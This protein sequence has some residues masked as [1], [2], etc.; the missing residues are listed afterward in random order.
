MPDAGARDGL[1]PDA[2]AR[3]GLPP[4]A[5]AR[6]AV[7]PDGPR[8]KDPRR[9]L[10]AR[11]E[12]LA[13]RHLEA[14][15]FEVVERNFRTRYGELDVIARDARFLVFCE[16]KTRIVRGAAGRGA[17]EDVLGPF[18]AIGPRKQRQ[19][20]A[21]AREWLSQASLDGPGGPRLSPPRPPEIRFDAI[22]I[23]FDASGR[24]LSLEHL[25]AAF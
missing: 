11:G 17:P 6:D 18:A 16:V 23:G 24:L 25:E 8:P 2:N 19:V 22:G 12:G 3:D 9:A 20:R 14:R 7:A 5:G 13:A 15:G 4:D 21:M 10:G 1:P